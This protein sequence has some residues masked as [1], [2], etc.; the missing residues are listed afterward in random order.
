LKKD[1]YFFGRTNLI[2]EIL[3]RYHSGEH[4]SLF[5]LRK[6]GKTSIVYA[7]QRRLESDNGCVVSLD[8]ESP[9]VH[10][11]Q[12]NELLERLVKLYHQA[13]RSKLK[14]DT[15]GRYNPKTAAD[16]FEEDILKIYRSKKQA[17][18]LFIFDEIERVSPKTGSSVHWRDGEDFIY[19]WQTMRGF[20]QKY[21]N[22]LCYMLVGPWGQVLPFAFC[23]KGRVRSCI[24]TFHQTETPHYRPLS[25]TE[26]EW[27]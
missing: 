12:W 2:N 19:F 7:I 9:S 20:Y 8:C 26:C 13:K 1:T 25:V 24:N 22:V 21:P 5:G 27:R 6:S 11:L 15:E 14:I 16:S 4:T 3:N 10:R 17:I 23:H 18:T